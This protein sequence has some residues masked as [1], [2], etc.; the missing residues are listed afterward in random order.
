MASRLC[1]LHDQL[2]FAST[3]LKGIPKCFLGPRGFLEAWGTKGKNHLAN[4]TLRDPL[5]GELA[6]FISPLVAAPDMQP[7]S[8]WPLEFLAE[9][10]LAD[11][12]VSQ[13]S[14]AIA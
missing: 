9:L 1:Q 2:P 6:R 10:D 12:E 13:Y 3:F 5:K 14:S 8:D 7:S 11:L 4:K